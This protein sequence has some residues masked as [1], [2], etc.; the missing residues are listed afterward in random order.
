M[1]HTLYRCAACGLVTVY[2][3]C[4]N[5]PAH[6]L[7]ALTA[8]EANNYVRIGHDA[9]RE[10]PEPQPQPCPL[11]PAVVAAFKARHGA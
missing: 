9:F 6:A 10:L 11:S 4:H 7:R 8:A 2:R 5:N 3:H 1:T